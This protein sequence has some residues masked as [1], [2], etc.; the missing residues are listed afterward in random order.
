MLDDEIHMV[1]VEVWGLN[2]HVGRIF[3]IIQSYCHFARK[4]LNMGRKIRMK[5]D[6]RLYKLD[7]KHTSSILVSD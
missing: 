5:A 6:T 1:T 7:L 2:Y 3:A 4:E